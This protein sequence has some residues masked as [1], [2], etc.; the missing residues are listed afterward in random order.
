VSSDIAES[1][2][3]KATLAWLEGLGYTTAN[4]LDIGPDGGAPE[5]LSYGDVLLIERVR[6]AVAKLNPALAAETRADAVNQVLQT[7]TPSLISENRRLH[8]F[9][10]EGVPVQVRRDDGTIS[11]DQVRL[12]DFEDP[13]AQLQTYK[14]Q[15]SSLFRTNAALVIS[16]GI[17]A[18]IGSLTAD[19]ERFM[20]WRT[21]TG[22]DVAPKGTPELEIVLKG[23]FDRR[24]F[25]DLVKD[26]IVFGDTG[27]D[28]AKIL[29]ATIS[30]TRCGT[31]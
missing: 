3:E 22:A 31:R 30:S 28:V 20:P 13:D 17:A 27:S 24:R 29:P 7:Q 26:F 6:T 16:D 11:G 8:R 12:I 19:R 1:H 21:V 4:G 14:A 18:R 5:R 10:I 23:V 25:L 15:I 9:I 2:V